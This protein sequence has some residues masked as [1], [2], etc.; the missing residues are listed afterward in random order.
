MK[1]A[2]I[3]SLLVLFIGLPAGAVLKEKN[4]RQT[5]NVLCEELSNTHKEQRQ[6]LQ[7]FEQ[8]NLGFKK[9]IGRDLELCNDIELMLYSQKDQNV[10]DVTYAC[11]QATDLYN[12]LS[13]GRSFKQFEEQQDEQ[14]AQYENLIN[15]LEKISPHL[16]TT[17]KMKAT[18]DSCVFLARAIQ[19]D[20]VA[21]RETMHDNHEQ[22]QF[23]ADKA[24][25]LNDY[26]LGVYDRIRE[27][28]F[29]NGDQS[30]FAIL[31]NLS[32]MIDQAKSDIQEKYGPARKARSEWRG[33]LVGFLFIFM[34][35]YMVAATA[36]SWLV[37][38]FAIPKRF[39][40]L[41]FRKKRSSIVVC[42]AAAVFGVATLVISRSLT[43]HN[44]MTMAT[45]LLSEYAWLIVVITLSLIIRL[46][47]DNVKS[48]VKLY[49][50]VLVV[51]F[52]VFFYRIVFMPNTI[53]NLTFPAIL[54]IC[55]L[56]Q[57]F[58]IKRHNSNVPRSDTFYSWLSLIVMAVSCV[59]AWMGYTL[60]SVQVLIWWI[61]Q[62]T[63]IQTITVIYDLLHKY[64]EKRIP[65]DAD[66]RRTWFYDAIY[67]MI[68]PIA[69][70]LSVGLSLYWA[71]TVFDLTE[72]CKEI[73]H[74][75]FVNQP[76]VIVLSLDRILFCVAAAF[77]FNYVIYLVIQGISCGKNIKPR[78]KTK[79]SRCQ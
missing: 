19:R 63:L 72:W 38:R 6:R 62:L 21:N 58:V 13:R 40:T 23:V 71:A 22:R 52:V 75:K 20:I 66:I 35:V 34:G 45:Q 4:M 12:R 67:K 70:T 51:G 57:L 36:I 10:F 14:I 42:A 44:F 64:E 69:A 61:M 5:L 29:V 17:S 7:R 39:I 8:R 25:Q 9:Q 30:Y 11:N 77:V 79:L 55:T 26:A 49:V 24:K 1:K 68:I 53:V 3:L 18:R 73:F 65:K 48:G 76:G 78:A 74:Y 56:W 47:G 28:I 2:I 15:A 37:M 27:S 16:L 33:P 60:M 59:M 32:R 43:G 41:T 50:P 54:L 46:D 31:G